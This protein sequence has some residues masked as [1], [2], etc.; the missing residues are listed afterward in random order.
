MDEA[1][2]DAVF[3]AA[4]AALVDDDASEEERQNLADE[5]SFAW[6]P[7]VPDLPIQVQTRQMDPEL[8]DALRSEGVPADQLFLAAYALAHLVRF[9]E[10]FEPT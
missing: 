7:E 3:R 8:R 10:P 5:L 4:H 2:R 9:G 1:F 6:P